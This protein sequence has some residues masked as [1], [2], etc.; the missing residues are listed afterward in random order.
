MKNVGSLLD[1]A[2]K[3]ILIVRYSH[4]FCPGADLLRHH[5]THANK[6]QIKRV[7]F[8]ARLCP[9]ITSCDNETNVVKTLRLHILLLL[10][11][12]SSASFSSVS[13]YFC[14][15]TNHFILELLQAAINCSHLIR[16][17][18]KCLFLPPSHYFCH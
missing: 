12:P 3:G 4:S 17:P 10:P 1:Q 18:L 16:D 15:A 14:A 6:M 8:F 13:N 11:G 9:S 7:P 5:Y 2:E